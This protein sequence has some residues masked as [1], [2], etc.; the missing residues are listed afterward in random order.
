MKYDIITILGAT[1][2]GKTT[3]AAHLA[4]KE[5]AEIVS[6][7][8]RQ[9]YRKMTIGTG[10]DYDDYIIN[11][12]KI[13]YHLIDI[14]DAGQ[15]YNVYEYQKD[16]VEVYNDL[17]T[18]NKQA[19]LCGGS[20]MY[21]EAV[22]KGYKLVNVPVNEK[23]RDEL[24]KQTHE[25]LIKSLKL[26]KKT[27]NK[28]DFDTKKRTIRAIEIENYT[29]DNDIDFDDFPKI[30]N[31]NFGIVFD[32]D[33]RRKRISFRLKERLKNGMIDEVKS[34]LN[35]GISPEI[36]LYYGLEYKYITMYIIGNIKYDEMFDSLET[37]IHQFSKRQ[38]TWFRRME[39]SGIKI[40]W[41]DGNMSIDKK[42]ELIK[43]KLAL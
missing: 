31:I 28:S 40:N 36:L 15:K 12:I 4:Y 1:A 3:L 23:L 20:G 2:S 34:L 10:K 35:L 38:M 21:I 22:I 24:Q 9:V 14:V 43:K 39:R 16:F 37:A 42:I 27:H 26:L 5:N 13:P 7:D 41:I 17:K 25:N 11:G 19:V 18:R 29:S 33:S 6:A 32:R 30:N 8:S